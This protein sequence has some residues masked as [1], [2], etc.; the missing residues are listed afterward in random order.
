MP[1][2]LLSENHV[3]LAL[4]FEQEGYTYECTLFRVDETTIAPAAF[5]DYR[6]DPTG[7]PDF[8]TILTH[9]DWEIDEYHLAFAV[10]R[11]QLQKGT[12]F[13]VDRPCFAVLVYEGRRDKTRLY[14]C[15][16]RRAT[17]TTTTGTTDGAGDSEIMV[18][19]CEEVEVPD[20]CDLH[21]QVTSRLAARANAA[22]NDEDIRSMVARQ[23]PITNVVEWSEHLDIR[24]TVEERIR[25]D[26]QERSLNW[27]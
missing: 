21:R 3:G 12:H 19:S 15:T 27:E 14:R 18:A 2:I 26:M 7:H 13:D 5:V 17:E 25:D 1:G 6:V 24:Q 4:P 10:A 11:S 20:P 9:E 8:T 16:Y 22:E 23:A